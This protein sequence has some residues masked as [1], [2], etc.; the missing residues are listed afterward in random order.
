MPLYLLILFGAFGFLKDKSRLA[1]SG[2][3]IGV[4]MFVLMFKLS[5]YTGYYALI[6]PL[7]PILFA[8]VVTYLKIFR[9]LWSVKGFS[10]KRLVYKFVILFIM[11]YPL[12]LSYSLSVQ[13]VSKNSADIRKEIAK[14]FSEMNRLKELIPPEERNS[15]MYWSEGM[16]VSNWILT[17]GIFP[18]CRF[19]NNVKAFVNIDPN[20]KREWLDAA[21]ANPPKWLVY[22]AHQ[23]EFSGKKVNTWIKSFRINRDS[24]VEKFF[25][26]KYTFVD[27]MKFY[28]DYFWLFRLKE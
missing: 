3:F 12:W 6:T 16:H 28:Q 2:L 26:E 21:R 18:C 17:T 1:V 23:S 7:L 14:N 20:V 10:L 19:F 5:P 22:S 11:I 24:D 9:E 13:V 27:G 4:I 8:T 15:V 25:Q